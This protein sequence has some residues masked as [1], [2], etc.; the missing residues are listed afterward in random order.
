MFQPF[1][2]GGP[3]DKRFTDVIEPAIADADLDA[4]RVDR[5]P[6]ATI[7]IDK[8]EETIRNAAVCVVDISTENPNV[9]YELGFAIASR[10]PVVMI[11]HKNIKLPFDIRHRNIVFYSL[12][13]PSDFTELKKKITERLKAELKLREK[14]VEL[15]E[16][17]PTPMNK[18]S[19]LRYH[20]S[21]ALALLMELRLEP[22]HV[23]SFYMLRKSME[24]AGFNS[25]ATNLAIA[26]LQRLGMTKISQGW[27][28]S[29][30]EN[31]EGIALTETGESWLLDHIDELDLA[32]PVKKRAL[33][34][35]VPE[36]IRQMTPAALP[37]L[38][39][40]V[41]PPF[42]KETKK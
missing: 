15:S 42:H 17:L 13:A 5:D 20:E 24:N 26:Q 35:E 39:P 11:C 41:L 4:Y 37:E 8:L 18:S 29:I 38:P 28:E 33:S 2:D 23:I 19:G 1:D 14:E 9:W 36:L 10:I 16:E 7:P 6:S 32:A 25:T 27:D 40:A 22:S 30:R 21:S 12:D 31:Y 34:S 3:Y